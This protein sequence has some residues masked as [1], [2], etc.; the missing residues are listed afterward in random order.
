MSSFV[1]TCLAVIVGLVVAIVLV[2]RSRRDRQ[3]RK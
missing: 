1:L 3:A 2:V